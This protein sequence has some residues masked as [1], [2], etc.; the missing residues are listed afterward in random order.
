[1]I[2]QASY[3][4][5]S[6]KRRI[7]LGFKEPSY[8]SMQ[9]YIRMKFL[10]DCIKNYATPKSLVALEVGVFK[11]CSLV[12][13]SKACLRK[14]INRIYGMDLFTGTESWGQ[15][16]DTYNEASS[17]MKSYGLSDAVTLLRSHSLDYEWKDNID[18]LHI[19]ADHSYE[20][21]LADANKYLPF[22]NKEGIVIFDDYDHEH[23]G[24]Q[25]AVHEIL[26][27]NKYEIIA[28]NAFRKAFGSICLK[29][30][31]E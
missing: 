26:M 21:A 30:I 25:Q 13:L 19:D 8:D 31:A 15:N 18:V 10:Y 29:K 20:A 5:S 9:D 16:F 24:V 4:L 23:L 7:E 1:M 11:G 27:S 6:L 17:R 3:L 28:V 14:G 2:K 22:L 12:F